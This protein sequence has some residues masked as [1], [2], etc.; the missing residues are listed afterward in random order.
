MMTPDQGY[1][2]DQFETVTWAAD[3][4]CYTNPDRSLQ[5]YLRFLAQFSDKARS[6][7]LFA[8]ALDVVGDHTA[9]RRRSIPC[10]TPIRNLG[11]S[12]AYVAQNGAESAPSMIPWDQ[13]DT[14]FIGGTTEWKLGEGAKQLA[15]VAHQKGKWV[16]MGRVNS[17]RRYLHAATFCDSADGTFIAFGP[18][19]NTPIVLSWIAEEQSALR[20][21][22]E[23]TEVNV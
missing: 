4:G 20:L 22:F 10:L 6:R 2:K 8:T 23:N 18:D 1:K 3:N 16:H 15:R 21:P 7:C 19:K 17:R 9:T 12:V 14:L 13:I 11:Y 5:G